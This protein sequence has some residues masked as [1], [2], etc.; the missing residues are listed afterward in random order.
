MRFSGIGARRGGIVVLMVLALP[1]MVAAIA[2]IVDIGR[3]AV[4]RA[5][6]QYA[7]D[8]A[9]YAGAASLAHSLND[10]AAANWRLYKAFR[11]LDNYF[12]KGAQQDSDTT[13]QRIKAYEVARD[14]AL[15]A[16][17]LEIAQMQE[18]ASAAASV[19]LKAS[20]PESKEE[21]VLRAGAELDAYEDPDD[22]WQTLQHDT[23]TGSSFVDPDSVEGG[24]Y[25]AL[26]Y[27]RK[28]RQPDAL[29]GIHAEAE[30]R[31]LLLRAALGESI[32][33]TASSAAQAFGGSVEDFALKA[34]D[35]LEDAQSVF[36]DDRY[37]A[38]YRA[39]IV[40]AWTDDEADQ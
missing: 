22:Q 20:A 24:S 9:A 11:D 10:I 28:R 7:V 16:M 27:L 2:L 6:L 1:L 31:P 26:K 35:S 25:D 8:R 32:E 17:D 37:D 29:L 33:V 13:Q 38:L 21:I 3:I 23:I 40:P 34:G 15:S 5:R 4:A 36:E 18:R 30:V 19:T 14:G 39:A 12:T